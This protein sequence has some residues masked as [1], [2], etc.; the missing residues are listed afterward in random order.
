MDKIKEA[1]KLADQLIDEATIRQ[2]GDDKGALKDEPESVE[3]SE[4]DREEYVEMEESAKKVTGYDLFK[5]RRGIGRKKYQEKLKKKK[6]SSVKENKTAQKYE[7]MPKT[8]PTKHDYATG[9]KGEKIKRGSMTINID[10]YSGKLTTVGSKK[11]RYL[12][13][14]KESE[15]VLDERY[16]TKDEISKLHDMRNDLADKQAATSKYPKLQK[17]NVFSKSNKMKKVAKKKKRDAA[18]DRM[19]GRANKGL[20][21]EANQVSI[22]Q[23][24]DTLFDKLER[25]VK[26][27]VDKESH[28]DP[29][30]ATEG[31]A[32]SI[33]RAARKAVGLSTGKDKKAY[34]AVGKKGNDRL[35][36]KNISVYHKDSNKQYK[37]MIK[38]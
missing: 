28:L 27:K 4:K 3:K 38:K 25:V 33:A 23:Q 30:P 32:N 36:N 12:D 13:K 2:V 8:K 17:L 22:A 1:Q 10:N 21:D 6:S 11:N 19:M 9:P 20:V 37:E 35:R 29:E 16:L 14:V 34:A 15:V 26:D 7:M 31:W 18:F 5:M 24:K